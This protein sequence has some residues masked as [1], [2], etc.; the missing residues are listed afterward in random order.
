MTAEDAIAEALSLSPLVFALVL[1][2]LLKRAR[3]GV[4]G[5][6]RSANRYRAR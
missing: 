4:E 6:R 2:V 3:G 5:A 1:L